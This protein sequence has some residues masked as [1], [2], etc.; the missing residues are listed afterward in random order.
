MNM[1]RNR[2]LYFAIVVVVLI[3]VWFAIGLVAV[4][5]RG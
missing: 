2:F 1:Q 5:T 4:G 3:V